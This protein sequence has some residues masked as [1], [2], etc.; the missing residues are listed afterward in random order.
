MEN[1][2][3]YFEDLVANKNWDEAKSFLSQK[4]ASEVPDFLKPLD[5]PL[6]LLVFRLLSH[7]FSAKIFAY[8]SPKQRDI[9]L[10]NLKNSEIQ[11]ILAGLSPDDRTELFE[12]LSRKSVK[13]LMKLLS[14]QDLKETKQLLKYPEDSVGRLMTP[15]F[16]AVKPN[17]TV[18]K[19]LKHIKSHGSKA[20]TIDLIYIVDSSGRFI[21]DIKIRNLLLAKPKV[22]VESL[23]SPCF[24]KLSPFDDQEKA[25]HL[26]KKHNLVALPVVDNQN[27]LL[28][29]VT[30]DDLIDIEEEEATEDFHKSGGLSVEGKMTPQ[31][32]NIMEASLNVLYRTRIGWLMILVAVN[33]FSGAAMA[34]FESTIAEAIALV[35]FLPLLIDSGGNAGAQASTLMIRALSLGDVKVGDWFKL[36]GREFVVTGALGVTMAVGVMLIGLFRGGPDVA[37]IAA[38]S[39][40]LIVIVGG[41]IGMSIPFLFMKFKKDPAA[42]SGPLITSVADICGVLIYFYVANLYLGL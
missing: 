2:L 3:V 22:K 39:M 20:E 36:I 31:I 7:K 27:V 12:E 42:A 26:I 6:K 9:F 37:I 33:I 40:I 38:I 5:P 4:H 32:G 28:G 35:F 16:L 41:T 21:D 13:K 10:K 29:I 25:L 18:D 19:T 34:N 1:E 14:S 15:D 24:A 11:R 8:L 17:W 30:I 23:A